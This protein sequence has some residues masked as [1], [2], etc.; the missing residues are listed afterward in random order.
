MHIGKEGERILYGGYP[1]KEIQRDVYSEPYLLNFVSLVPVTS[2]EL[3]K[4]QQ[5]EAFNRTHM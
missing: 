3:G 1:Y 2:V 5:A 4:D